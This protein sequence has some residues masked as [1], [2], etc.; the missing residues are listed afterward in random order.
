VGVPGLPVMVCGVDSPEA[1]RALV[2]MCGWVP[3][4]DL[5]EPGGSGF[6]SSAAALI[7]SKLVSG[8]VGSVQA[9]YSA[10]FLLPS[11]LLGG[12]Q[13]WVSSGVTGL[14]NGVAALTQT[15]RDLIL[16]AIK[17]T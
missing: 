9:D 5:P 11:N 12:R 8:G 2:Y 3:A 17:K 16:N 15:N 13:R 4:L 7:K 14:K 1:V 10:H 6:M